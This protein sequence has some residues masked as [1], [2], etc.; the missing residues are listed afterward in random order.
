MRFLLTPLITCILIGRADT[1]WVPKHQETKEIGTKD[2][3]THPNYNA[4]QFFEN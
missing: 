4:A 2:K 1:F 3:E